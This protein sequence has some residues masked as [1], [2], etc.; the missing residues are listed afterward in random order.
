MSESEKFIFEDPIE[1]YCLKGERKYLE[2]I[3]ELS[4]RVQLL[5]EEN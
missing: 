1:G 4:S 2:E 3:E 5:I